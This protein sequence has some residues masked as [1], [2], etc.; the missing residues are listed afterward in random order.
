[1]SGKQNRPF[2]F[3]FWIPK[4]LTRD[5]E[6]PQICLARSLWC[7]EYAMPAVPWATVTD[8]GRG[9]RP[10]PAHPLWRRD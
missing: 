10:P 7:R 8:S 3:S 9:E 6:T 2:A 4:A 1:M 5:S